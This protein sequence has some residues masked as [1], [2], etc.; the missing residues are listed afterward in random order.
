MYLLECMG[1]ALYCLAHLYLNL[2]GLQ[3]MQGAY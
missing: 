3:T 2:L 1:V